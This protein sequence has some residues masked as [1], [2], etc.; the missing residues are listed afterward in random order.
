M[1]V[2]A[3]HGAAEILARLA[4]Y[5]PQTIEVEG[6]AYREGVN[7][8]RIVGGV[9]GNVIPDLCEVEV[10]FRYAPARTLEQAIAHV[11]EVF[12]G[13]EIEV[14]DGASAARPGL[15]AP[16]AQDFL[17]AGGAEA[18]PKY[19]W[20]DVA[21]FGELGI[22]AINYGPGDALLAHHDEERVPVSQIERVERGL[23]AWLS[24]H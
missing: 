20:T 10:N 6:L 9:A 5:Q 17:A 22:P 8:V 13:F 18:K 4:A 3:I 7:A 12:D 1:G 23:R 14:T 15:D 21:R 2:N 24:A 11:R 19:G 16:L